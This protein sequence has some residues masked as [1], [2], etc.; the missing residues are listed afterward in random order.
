VTIKEWE[1]KTDPD[2]F[3]TNWPLRP[4]PAKNEAEKYKFYEILD[5]DENGVEKIDVSHYD[6]FMKKFPDNMVLRYQADAL[7][8]DL[9]KR[10]ILL[11]S[12]FFKL[13]HERALERINKFCGND[14][15]A[16]QTELISSDK[17]SEKFL[18]RDYYAIHFLFEL[19]MLDIQ[20]TEFTKE[21]IRKIRNKEFNLISS[22]NICKPSY[23][24]N[25]WEGHYMGRNKMSL[26]MVWHPRIAWELR[27]S[28]N[29]YF[30]AADW[31]KRP[32][33]V[34]RLIG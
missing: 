4:L 14:F 12:G 1:T 9:D 34:N 28:K 21:G 27:N 32:E 20:R 26:D 24:D 19:D 33:W 30:V 5:L 31:F 25:K 23:Y 11:V 29:I 2:L 13:I 22:T 7:R 16:I 10:E 8:K 15:Q 3:K 17:C 6:S 18:I